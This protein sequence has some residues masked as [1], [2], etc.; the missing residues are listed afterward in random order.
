MQEYVK[1]LVFFLPCKPND[2]YGGYLMAVVKMMIRRVR[3]KEK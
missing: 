2:K 3:R 1:T